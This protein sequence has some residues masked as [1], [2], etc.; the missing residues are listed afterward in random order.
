MEVLVGGF[1]FERQ[2]YATSKSDGRYRNDDTTRHNIVDPVR[3]GRMLFMFTRCVWILLLQSTTKSVDMTL[4]F[5]FARFI[6]GPSILD[7]FCLIASMGRQAVYKSLD[8]R[9]F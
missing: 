9:L 3:Q 1:S 2:V 7:Q 4:R 8:I 5:C 6:Y